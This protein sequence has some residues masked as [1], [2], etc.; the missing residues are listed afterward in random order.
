M[1][2]LSNIDSYDR[3]EF[4]QK[5]ETLDDLQK[6][7][8]KQRPKYKSLAI[9]CKFT[10]EL[11]EDA[12]KGYR[13]VERLSITT[14]YIKCDLNKL[15]SNLPALTKIRLNYIHIDTKAFKSFTNEWK[16]LKSFQLNGIHAKNF[17]LPANFFQNNCKLEEL[18]L[19]SCNLQAVPPTLL[20]NLPELSSIELTNNNIKRIPKN[21]FSANTKLRSV[22]LAKN[23]IK[24]LPKG[25]LANCPDMAK[26][27]F[28]FWLWNNPMEIGNPIAL[29][30]NI[31][32]L[33]YTNSNAFF[34]VTLENSTTRIFHEPL[35][36][37]KSVTKFYKD[38]IRNTCTGV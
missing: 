16:N 9:D 25:L 20:K 4:Q 19:H 15:F 18:Q 8:L 28:T 12:F 3:Y 7:P 37:G 21:F 17:S 38:C 35:G 2:K 13:N 27:Y 10:G 31:S 5:I 14:G 6:V 29:N 11:T 1:T 36:D 22:K 34:S 24:T 26:D 32:I 30:K 33:L 23:Q